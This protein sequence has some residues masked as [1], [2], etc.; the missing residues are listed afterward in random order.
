MRGLLYRRLRQKL[1]M[2]PLLSSFSANLQ[3]V[4]GNPFVAGFLVVSNEIVILP[5]RGV[6]SRSHGHAFLHSGF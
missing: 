3:V 2:K 6:T 4:S 5:Q 1:S